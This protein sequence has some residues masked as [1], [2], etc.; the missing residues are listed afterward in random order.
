VRL[1]TADDWA[2]HIK[3]QA[4]FKGK[5]CR[6]SLIVFL[7][8]ILMA[9]VSWKSGQCA[10]TASGNKT[11]WQVYAQVGKGDWNII[12]GHH[13]WCA[14]Y[15]NATLLVWPFDNIGPELLVCADGRHCLWHCDQSLYRLLSQ[16]IVSNHSLERSFLFMKIR[17]HRQLIVLSIKELP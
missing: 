1:P 13:G 10:P 15:P 9:V 16:N 5:C 4:L 8:A 7:G 14:A 12:A 17:R 11:T 6:K 3:W 2:P